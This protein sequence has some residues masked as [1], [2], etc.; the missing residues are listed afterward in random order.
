MGRAHELLI[1]TWC[2][3]GTRATW[4]DGTLAEPPYGPDPLG[5]LEFRADHRMMCVLVDSRMDQAAAGR[6]YVSYAGVYRFD[7]TTV[8][9][10]VVH[11]SDAAR[12]GGDEVR[13]VTFR[14]RSRM[15]L[16]PPP[17]R[18]GSRLVQLELEW[19]RRSH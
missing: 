15:T 9:T 13:T 17:R 11:S 16:T 18:R 19:T 2:L 1:G 8:T 5:L 3:S 6:D 10:R 4:L 12:I 7:G 14:D